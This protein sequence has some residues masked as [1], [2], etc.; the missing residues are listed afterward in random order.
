[1][2]ISYALLMSSLRKVDMLNA[3]PVALNWTLLS[4]APTLSAA[5]V[6]TPAA[7]PPILMRH[8][9]AHNKHTA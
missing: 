7:F 8:S 5:D 3:F 1:M 4:Q 2:L 9:P 6:S